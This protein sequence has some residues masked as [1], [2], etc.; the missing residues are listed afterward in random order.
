[1]YYQMTQ[2][3]QMMSEVQCTPDATILFDEIIYTLLSL[4]TCHDG[5]YELPAVW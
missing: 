4:V 1:M 3:N 5:R 2:L